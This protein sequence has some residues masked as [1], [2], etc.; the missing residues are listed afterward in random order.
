MLVSA[1]MRATYRA[2]AAASEMQPSDVSSSGTLPIGLLARKAADLLSLPI[3]K[4]GSS[5]ST[6][7]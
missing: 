1:R 6:P 5:M 2:I 4:A 3:S 7:L